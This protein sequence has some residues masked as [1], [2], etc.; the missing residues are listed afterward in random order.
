[1]KPMDII[2][3][4]GEWAVSNNQ[5]DVL[6]TFALASCVAVTVYSPIRRV[7]GMIHIALPSPPFT[8]GIPDR[9]GYYATTGIPLLLHEMRNRYGCNKGELDI[10]LFGGARSVSDRDVFQIG[11]RNLDTIQGILK[12]LHL[13]YRATET[14]GTYSRSLRM[15]V[16]TG[17]IEVTY[18][19]IRI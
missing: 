3:G 4:I 2:I 13:K 8:G 15:E 7:G 18:Q 19:P 17:R 11:Q 16:A 14:G 9:K 5:E 12:G 6:K 1:M 10:Q